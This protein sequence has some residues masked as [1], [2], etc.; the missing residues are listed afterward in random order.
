MY[1][2]DMLNEIGLE[3]GAVGAV[4]ADMGPQTSVS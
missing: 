3:G 1:G 2:P 4:G